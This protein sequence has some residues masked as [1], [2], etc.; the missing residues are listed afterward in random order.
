MTLYPGQLQCER[1]SVERPSLAP[2]LL[3]S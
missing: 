2:K 1:K 3:V